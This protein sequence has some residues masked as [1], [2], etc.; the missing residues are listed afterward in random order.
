MTNTTLIAL[1]FSTAMLAVAM[2]GAQAGERNDEA[3]EAGLLQA[4]KITA[5][6]AS[7]A[8]IA[9][10][11]GTVSSVQLYGASGKPAF[12]VE[13]VDSDGGQQDL[14]VDAVTGEVMKMAAGSEDDGDQPAEGGDE[15]D[16][17]QD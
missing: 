4:A 3:A 17:G 7:R 14:S 8:A 10:V 13:V 11:P 16:T 15:G 9:K 5:E 6:D 1:I 12:H 2:P